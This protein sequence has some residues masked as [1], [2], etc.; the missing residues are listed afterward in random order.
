VGLD[1][2]EQN[3]SRIRQHIKAESPQAEALVNSALDREI[4]DGN[5]LVLYL[6]SDLLA[7]KLGKEESMR[8]VEQAL[9]SVL[10]KPCRVRGAVKG[11]S[12]QQRD[13]SAAPAQSQPAPG[14][15]RAPRAEQIEPEPSEL[16]ASDPY[17]EAVSDPVI[18][19]LV[20]RGGQ[21]TDVQVLPEE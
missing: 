21:V 1:E 5:R 10:G 17:Q 3:W 11:A 6:A 16:V 7:S 18:Q 9:S 20:S 12:T 15:G 13:V 8:I 4:E 14:A 19:D 2:V